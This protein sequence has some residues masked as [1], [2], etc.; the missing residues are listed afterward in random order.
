MDH[1]GRRSEDASGSR[2]RA[3]DV[4]DVLDGYFVRAAGRFP[5]EPEVR[6]VIPF[7]R[8]P[9]ARPQ[10]TAAPEQPFPRKRMVHGL[11]KLTLGTCFASAG[12]WNSGYSLKPNIFAVMLAGNWRRA[13]LYFWTVSL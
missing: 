12:A 2:L 13:V 6:Q 7:A 5:N 4:A 8:P 1:D 3:S 9:G 10:G 11:P